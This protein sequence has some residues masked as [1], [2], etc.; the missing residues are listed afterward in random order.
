MQFAHRSSKILITGRSGTGK[1]TYFLRYLVGADHGKKFVFDGEGEL[2]HKLGLAA[3]RS[4]DQLGAQLWR[5]S[6]YVIFDPSAMFAGEHRKAFNFFCE[7]SFTASKSIRGKKLL[8]VDELQKISDSH[9]IDWEWSLVLETGRR[10][11]LDMVAIS[12]APN[13]IHNRVRNQ[14]T[15][16]VTFAH[17]D[18]N[19]LS[20]LEG[21][22]FDPLRIQSLPNGAFIARNLV[23][24]AEEH[25]R[26]F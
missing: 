25:G 9:S 19:A 23:N 10:W 17:N 20:F 21:V 1:T 26:V 5:R 13:L 6:P 12:Q 14:L 15:E 22:G 4:T 16:A 3:A 18:P 7:W 11:G 2:G 24:Q 8:A